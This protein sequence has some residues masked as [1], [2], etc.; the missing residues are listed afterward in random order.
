M[1][2]RKV[3]KVKNSRDPPLSVGIGFEDFKPTSKVKK[4]NKFWTDSKTKKLKDEILLEV[5]SV[6]ND[7]TAPFESRLA[8]LEN[9]FR[10]FKQN[11]E[12][13]FKAIDD[14]NSAYL[15][16]SDFSSAIKERNRQD[17]DDKQRLLSAIKDTVRKQSKRIEEVNQH[18]SSSI[19][20]LYDK[21]YNFA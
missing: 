1:D 13:K 9:D 15:L 12:E 3:F 5:M 20:S 19:Q 7:I 17:H 4:T 8:V 10:L 16:K 21:R 18:L 2:E 11:V 14:K 6:L